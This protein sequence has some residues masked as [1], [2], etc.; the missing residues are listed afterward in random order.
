METRACQNCKNEFEIRSESLAFY[1]KMG[2]HIPGWCPRCRAVRRFLF[3]N[4]KKYYRRE[5][6]VPAATGMIISMYPP[7]AVFPVYDRDYWWS[8]AW[9]AK[10]YSIDYDLGKSFFEQWFE[11]YSKVP[12]PSLWSYNMQHSPYTNYCGDSNNVYMCAG[13]FFSENCGFSYYGNKN[14]LVYDSYDINQCELSYQIVHGQRVS[15]STHIWDSK[16]IIDSHYLYDCVNCQDCFMSANL[17]NKR[18][19]FRGKEYDK[20]TY[21]ELLKHEGIEMRSKQNILDQEFKDMVRGSKHRFGYMVNSKNSSGDGI[22]NSENVYEGYVII[23][24]R[25]VEYSWRVARV[26]NVS[27]VAGILD[28]E[29]VYEAVVSGYN[30]NML[31]GTMNCKANFNSSYCAYVSN[32]HDCFGCVGLRNASYCIFNKQYEKEE[33][34]TLRDEIIRSMNEKPYI[35]TNGREYRFGD[36]YPVSMSP[37]P[38]DASY[39]T[40]FYG[41]SSQEAQ[42]RSYTQP[43]GH[44]EPFVSTLSTVPETIG[45]CDE[46]IVKEIIPCGTYTDNPN[47]RKA[48]RLETDELTFYT[49]MNLPIPEYCPSCRLEKR[50]SEIRGVV[51]RDATCDTCGKNIRTTYGTDYKVVCEECYQQE[52]L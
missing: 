44:L 25:D 36:F 16:E 42:E 7:E 17:R 34:F 9:D 2:V 52:V 4:D 45:E 48:F 15:R 13:I 3:R 11:L 41:V 38:Y 19:V 31:V 37:F 10:E 26:Q 47:C 8:D 50:L 29:N 5:N 1:K 23:E 14:T 24:S 51:L 27:D 6:N 12:H 32:S 22:V 43:S 28:S 39:A 18:Y 49:R 20:E 35:D 40:N 33:Y 30:N 46:T 21:N